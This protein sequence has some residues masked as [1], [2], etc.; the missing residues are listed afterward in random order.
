AS[1]HRRVCSHCQSEVA[2]GRGYQPANRHGA[3][4]S[5][6]GFQAAIAPPMEDTVAHKN[7]GIGSVYIHTVFRAGTAKQ[8]EIIEVEGHIAGSYDDA[9]TA[10]QAYEVTTSVVQARVGDRDGKRG[11]RDSDTGSRKPQVS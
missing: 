4:L 1:T 3:R 10:T 5:A 7:I 8:N 11:N 6:I 9:I 2:V